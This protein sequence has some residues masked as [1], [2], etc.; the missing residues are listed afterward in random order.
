MRPDVGSRLVG[1]ASQVSGDSVSAGLCYAAYV[2]SYMYWLVVLLILPSQLGVAGAS[3]AAAG[4]SVM[5]EDR[6]CM[7][8]CGALVRPAGRLVFRSL[9]WCVPMCVLEYYVLV[10]RD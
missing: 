6:G 4:T 7:Q 5:A 3:V 2:R 10:A 1:Q 8:S 9:D